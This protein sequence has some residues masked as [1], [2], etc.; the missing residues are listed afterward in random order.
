MVATAV[1]VAVAVV[2]V[3]GGGLSFV[4]RSGA[5]PIRVASSGSIEDRGLHVTL[6]A[7]RTDARI[8]DT[9]HLGLTIE[10]TSDEQGSYVTDCMGEPVWFD[11]ADRGQTWP[12]GAGEYKAQLLDRFPVQSY[13]L[14]GGPYLVHRVPPEGSGA[15]CIP[16]AE[17]LTVAAHAVV[18]DQLTWKVGRD[19]LPDQPELDVQVVAYVDAQGPGAVT[20]SKLGSSADPPDPA[21]ATKVML[22]LTI[23]DADAPTGR[24]TAPLAI[25]AALA[26]PQVARWVDAHPPGPDA[27]RLSNL[28]QWQGSWYVT[29]A[30]GFIRTDGSADVLQVSVSTD[31]GSV[32]IH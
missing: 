18:H 8:G 20:Q 13:E 24:M 25:D 27:S 26:D 19:P 1:A 3:V 12:G 22:P 2:V 7:D 17:Y 15:G 21:G 30:T 28:A 10:N 5:G 16:E 31:D 9:V 4:G 32:T 14:A 11:W 29:F 23:H 6:T